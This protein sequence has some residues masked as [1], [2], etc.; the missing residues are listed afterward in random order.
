MNVY[1]L[2][3]CD[4]TVKTRRWLEE[5]DLTYDFHDYK[6]EG[7]SKEKLE[8]WDK[9]IGWQTLLNKRST[10]WRELTPAQQ[11]KITNKEAALQLMLEKNSIIK[12]PVIEQQGKLLVGYDEAILFPGDVPR[13][14]SVYY[15]LPAYRSF[16]PRTTRCLPPCV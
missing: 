13:H 12:R 11:E 10:T 14:L 6:L 9:K 2:Q 4:I 5:H 3:S 16:L 15:L 7:I 8:E 1:G